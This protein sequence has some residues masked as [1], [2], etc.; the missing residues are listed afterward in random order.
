MQLAAEKTT[1]NTCK[2]YLRQ[3]MVKYI[4]TPKKWIK[5]SRWCQGKRDPQT[6]RIGGIYCRNG[7]SCLQFP[8]YFITNQGGPATET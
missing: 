7:G 8:S 5:S 6:G 3:C 1:E 2:Q 4:E